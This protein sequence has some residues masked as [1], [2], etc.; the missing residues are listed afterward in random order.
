MEKIKA[1]MHLLPDNDKVFAVGNVTIAGF[2]TVKN[3]RVMKG[4]EGPYISMPGEYQNSVWRNTVYAAS[5]EMQEK[6]K[7][8]VFLAFKEAV[9]QDIG[10]YKSD[11]NIKIVPLDNKGKLKGIATVEIF[12]IKVT[13]IKILEKTGNT[14]GDL[15]VSMP[16]YRTMGKNG[17][18]WHDVVYPTSH[19]ARWNLTEWV[20]DAYREKMMKQ[21]EQK[22]VKESA[23]EQEQCIDDII[24]EMK[25][26][27]E[28]NWP[29]T[30]EQWDKIIEKVTRITEFSSD[31]PLVTEKLVNFLE[32]YSE[33]EKEIEKQKEYAPKI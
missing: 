6:L 15:Y 11:V 27:I 28:D 12:G 32:T 13:N 8:A 10:V 3:V 17:E 23:D 7:Q 19:L 30:D 4:K 31:N 14:S 20:L 16:Q 18:E 24:E 29:L 26:E 2:I 21:S 22:E 5:P 9:T 25:K 33:K 1:E